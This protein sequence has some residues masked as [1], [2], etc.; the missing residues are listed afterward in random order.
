VHRSKS[1]LTTFPNLFM[2]CSDETRSLHKAA[3]EEVPIMTREQKIVAIG[4][5]SGVVTMI[6]AVV[7]IYQIWPTNP[8]LADA[9]SRLA[10]TVQANAFAVIPLATP[11]SS[12][13]V[14]GLCFFCTS[15]K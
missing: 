1:G 7:G 4:S 6:A 3:Q 8:S 2:S 12:A 5:A 11:L 10:Y 15:A 14:H 13:R 9:A